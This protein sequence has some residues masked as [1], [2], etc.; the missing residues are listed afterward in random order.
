M[1]TSDPKDDK[2]SGDSNTPL[3]ENAA[4]QELD[5]TVITNPLLQHMVN[6]HDSARLHSVVVEINLR[7]PDGQRKIKAEVIQKLRSML[8]EG[9]TEGL[10]AAYQKG[11][12][13]L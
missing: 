10:N 7:H 4:L 5:T 9:G 11:H 13:Y 3:D 12:P 2:R 1:T 8:E 6:D